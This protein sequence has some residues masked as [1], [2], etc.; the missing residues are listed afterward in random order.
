MH[1]SGALTP[2]NDPISDM[3]LSEIVEQEAISEAE[4]ED[5]EM[6]SLLSSRAWQ[7][8]AKDM[9]T[10]IDGFRTGKDL[11]IDKDSTLADIGQRFVIASTLAD[12][13]QAYLDR[14]TGAAERVAESERKAAEQRAKADKPA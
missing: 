5:K 11:A 10:D 6:A 8:I 9:Q 13:L 4:V 1:D 2:G 12:R 3:D 7:R 14:V